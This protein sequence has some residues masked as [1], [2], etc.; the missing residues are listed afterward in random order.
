MSTNRKSHAP[1]LLGLFAASVLLITSGNH[2]RQSVDGERY[3]ALASTVAKHLE[4]ARAEARVQFGDDGSVYLVEDDSAENREKAASATT[5]EDVNVTFA[6]G[7]VYL[8]EDE[9]ATRPASNT[10][11]LSGEELDQALAA[12]VLRLTNERRAQNGL[13]PLSPHTALEHAAVEH[14]QEM[15]NL[16]YFSHTSPTAG[17]ST[18]RQRVNQFGVNPQL[19]AEN[20]FE[21]SGYDLQ[22]TAAFAVESFMQ[23]PEHRKNLLN[24]SATHI[25]VGFASKDGSVSV[26][27]V[28]G[29]GL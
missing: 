24:P 28:F 7:N 16:N 19:V 5:G 18:T 26:T 15:R 13:S 14:S 12:E 2:L 8:V 27:Q 3:S 11:Q 1:L 9:V 4:V 10:P 29:A 22:K 17:K 25:G 6:N 21:C 20:I 23:S